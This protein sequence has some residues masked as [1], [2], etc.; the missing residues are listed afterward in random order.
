MEPMCE[1]K[2]FPIYL[3]ICISIRKGDLRFSY[4][5]R[6]KPWSGFDIM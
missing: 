2:I 3:M 4:R 1:T 5:W 6:F